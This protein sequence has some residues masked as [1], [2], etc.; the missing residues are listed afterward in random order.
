MNWLTVWLWIEPCR[1]QE[2]RRLD[3]CGCKSRHGKYKGINPCQRTQDIMD[4]IALLDLGK[5]PRHGNGPAE[6]AEYVL[7]RTCH[8]YRG[9]HCNHPKC[10]AATPI[11]A[12][13]R[14]LQRRKVA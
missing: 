2:Y 5:E 3:S 1:C 4:D 7:T 11:L 9:T 13:L 8:A 6:I 14:E 12:W 10:N